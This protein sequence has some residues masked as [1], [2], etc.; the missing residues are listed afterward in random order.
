MDASQ[1][2]HGGAAEQSPVKN[3]PGVYRHEGAK[4]EIITVPGNEGSIQADALV[5][6]GYT[7]VND[8]PSRV[9]LLAMQKKQLVKDLADEKRAKA[10]DEAELA[11]LVEAEL[12]TDKKK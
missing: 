2:P 4:A 11:A 8:L 7:R 6:V 9:E 10:A 5:R 3:L 1:L 12:A